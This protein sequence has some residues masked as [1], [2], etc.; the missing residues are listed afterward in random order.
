LRKNRGA[1]IYEVSEA[2][3]VSMKQITK[4]IREGRISLFDAPNMSYPCEVC[5]LLI[6]DNHM[7][8]ACRTKLVKSV[9]RMHSQQETDKKLN[10]T[11]TAFRIKDHH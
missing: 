4:F 1:T 2:A 9:N 8:E 10:S 7:C 6:R 11:T 3:E 5:G